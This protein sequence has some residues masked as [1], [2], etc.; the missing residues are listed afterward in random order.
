MN[1]STATGAGLG[2]P[3]V[4]YWTRAMT[5]VRAEEH[6]RRGLIVPLALH[7]TTA[8]G[9]AVAGYVGGHLTGRL[10]GSRRPARRRHR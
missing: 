8:V 1:A 9:A 6:R 7:V 5:S 3:A 2:D 10:T 4:E